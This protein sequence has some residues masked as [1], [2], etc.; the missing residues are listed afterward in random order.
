MIE[1]AEEKRGCKSCAEEERRHGEPAGVAHH[2]GNGAGDLPA[3]PAAG[4]VPAREAHA[5]LP[6]LWL[7]YIP[8]AVLAALLL[9]S[10]LVGAGS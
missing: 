10:L 2:A 4:V 7:K 9:P 5:A 3:A 6:G 1:S 8:V